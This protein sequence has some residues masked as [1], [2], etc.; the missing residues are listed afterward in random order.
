V[1]GRCPSVGV[2]GGMATLWHAQA[3]PGVSPSEDT[4]TPSIMGR[5]GTSRAWARDTSSRDMAFPS[6]CPRGPSRGLRPR[7]LLTLLY[8][9]LCRMSSPSNRRAV[10]RPAV[11]RVRWRPCVRHTPLAPAWRLP[12]PAA[13]PAA[14]A[15]ATAAARRHRRPVRRPAP[16][17]PWPIPSA[18]PA[19]Q[20]SLRCGTR[21]QR[22]APAHQGFQAA[23]LPKPTVRP[24]VRERL[25]RQSAF[26]G[27]LPN[28]T[29]K[30]W[31]RG[32]R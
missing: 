28:T 16:A 31:H 18:S 29:T 15:G 4:S 32:S 8:P 14:R 12:S 7:A 25:A 27:K 11:L 26:S 17:P 30:W 20:K 13:R 5:V 19:P 21:L 2:A 23:T 3:T 24:I 1:T 6:A 22:A 9:S 10:P